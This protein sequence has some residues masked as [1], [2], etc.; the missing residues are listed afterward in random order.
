MHRLAYSFVWFLA[1]FI[2]VKLIFTS[3]SLGYFWLII[4]ALS[5]FFG[6]HSAKK[7]K[8]SDDLSQQVISWL[9]KYQTLSYYKKEIFISEVVNRAV[10][11]NNQKDAL[12]FLQTILDAEPDNETAKGL[13]ISIWGTE[14]LN[15]Y[16]NNW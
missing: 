15:N 12:V 11:C 6:Y 7:I 10:K 9:E 16:T 3:Q 4:L 5:L 13:M 2:I 14:V 8:I 1:L